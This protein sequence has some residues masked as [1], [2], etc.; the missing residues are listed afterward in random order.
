MSVSVLF[1][2]AVYDYDQPF[3]LGA[4]MT[5]S[6]STIEETPLIKCL[7]LYFRGAVTTLG[8][9]EVILM[10]CDGNLLLKK[11]NTTLLQTAYAFS[12][13]SDRSDICIAI[14]SLW[15][16]FDKCGMKKGHILFFR[17][18][19]KGDNDKKLQVDLLTDSLQ[20][21][22]SIISAIRENNSLLFVEKLND[23]F[24]KRHPVPE[25]LLVNLFS[26]ASYYDADDVID[27]I[28]N[29][30]PEAVTPSMMEE[31]LA[32]IKKKQESEV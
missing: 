23:V 28:M 3:N 14:S 1:N 4:D 15:G 20:K 18:S 7:P 5:I 10:L 11:L 21:W 25:E 9:L 6:S 8:M 30:A 12:E 17:S 19:R 31:Y 24:N 26:I 2:K 16:T 22:I 32:L 13:N 27:C 29:R